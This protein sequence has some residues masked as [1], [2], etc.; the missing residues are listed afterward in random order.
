MSRSRTTV[1]GTDSGR[2]YEV[3][4]GRPGRGEPGV[5]GNPVRVGA[6]CLVCSRVHPAGD[7]LECYAI[8]LD[9]R[10]DADPEFAARVQALSGRV[11]GC[12]CG[13]RGACHG[14][15]LASRADD[16]AGVAPEPGALDR[17]LGPGAEA[18]GAGKVTA[19]DWNAAVQSQ[20]ARAVRAVTKL[21]CRLCGAEITPE[22]SGLPQTFLDA[23][24]F[25][26]FATDSGPTCAACALDAA[27]GAGPEPE[28]DTP[29]T[30]EN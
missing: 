23:L 14:L 10:I 13:A 2:P 11:L 25:L 1:V 19:F 29:D 4:I 27:P 26:A 30:E 28:P 24:G 20:A 6:P 3:Y 9:R 15:T 22:G 12:P 17:L 7:T 8:Y 18:G 21:R 5:F 16:L